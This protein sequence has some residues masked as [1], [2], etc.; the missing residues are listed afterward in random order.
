MGIACSLSILELEKSKCNI[1][2]WDVSGDQV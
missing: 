1:E 2:L